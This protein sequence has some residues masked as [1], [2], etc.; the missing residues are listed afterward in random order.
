MKDIGHRIQ[1]PISILE[2][3]AATIS[4]QRSTKTNT[5]IRGI[6]NLRWAWVK[7]L[8]NMAKIIAVKVTTNDNIADLLT[9]HQPKPIMDKFIR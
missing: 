4:F 8:R 3:N 9:K 6:Y 2:D 7:D 1:E 5:K